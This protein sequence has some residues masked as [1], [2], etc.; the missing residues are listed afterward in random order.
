[1][2]RP[3]ILAKIEVLRILMPGALFQR[4]QL[5]GYRPEIAQVQPFVA[6]KTTGKSRGL[7]SLDFAQLGPVRLFAFGV[8]RNI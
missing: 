7:N 1:M 3:Y 5:P 2:S 4:Q 6:T 8:W